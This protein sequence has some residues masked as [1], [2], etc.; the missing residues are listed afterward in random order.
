LKANSHQSNN[1][2]VMAAAKNKKGASGGAQNHIR[3]RLAYLHKASTYLFSQ[4]HSL[5]PQAYISK[6]ENENAASIQTTAAQAPCQTHCQT[7]E[8]QEKK[9]TLPPQQACIPR[10]YV[11]QMRGVSLKA[12]QRLSVDTKRSFC[13]RCDLLLVPG[14]TCKEVFRNASKGQKT[15]W[16]DVLVTRCSACETEKRI[17][18]NKARS[19][20]L[21]ARQ[22]E[23]KEKKEEEESKDRAGVS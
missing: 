1:K 12:Q 3:A 21:K 6:S 7:S 4:Q 22:Q 19:K 17:P 20:K 10:H 23:K 14:V 8:E 11:N 13:K 5:K 18:Q 16:A 15:P 2:K 9:T